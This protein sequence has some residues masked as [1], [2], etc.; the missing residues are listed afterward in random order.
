MK[1]AQKKDYLASSK[2]VITT[3]WNAIW[4]AINIWNPAILY[5]KCTY[6][7]RFLGCR[8]R[9]ECFLTNGG[10]SWTDFAP[11]PIIS[12]HMEDQ[13]HNTLHCI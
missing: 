11:H 3:D 4:I 2:Y 5:S 1:Y 10:E 6:H 9:T 13:D 7:F 8:N 12:Y